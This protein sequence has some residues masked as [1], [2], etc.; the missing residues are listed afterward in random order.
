MKRKS[1]KFYP[2]KI[3]FNTVVTKLTDGIV[4]LNKKGIVQF[5]NPAAQ[6]L[7]GKTSKE[8]LD[9]PFPYKTQL[10]KISEFEIVHSRKKKLIEI[11]IKKMDFK[12]R[13]FLL[14]SLR[15]I[16]HRQYSQKLHTE[17]EERKK[18]EEALKESQALF[19]SFMNHS[20]TISAMKDEKGRYIYVNEPLE[21]LFQTTFSHLKGKTDFD[22]LSEPTAR[23]LW[24][25]DMRVLSSGKM[26][27]AIE[28]V[29]TPDGVP[30]YWLVLKFPFLH[31]T[32]KHFVGAVGI[33]ITEKKHAEEEIKILAKFPS[34][35]PYPIFRISKEGTILYANNSALPLLQSWKRKI[36]ENAPDHLRK[37]VA[38]TLETGLKKHVEVDHEHQIFSFVFA[39]IID[40]GYVNIYAQD[41]TERKRLEHLKEEFVSTVSHELRTP[42]AILK[43]G[44]SQVWEGLHGD[45]SQEQKKILAMALKGVDRLSNIINDLLDISKIEA[46]RV[47]LKKRLIDLTD[48]VRE[49]ISIFQVEI[50]NRKLALKSQFPEKPVYVYADRGKIFQVLTNL[51]GNA[52]KFTEKGFIEICVEN[53]QEAVICSVSD[54]GRSISPKDLSKVFEKFQQFSRT[55]GPGERGTGLG[56]SICKGLVESHGGK[57]WVE[58]KLGRG[59]RF[60]FTLPHHTSK[61]IFRE[62]ISNGIKEALREKSFVSIIIFEIKNFDDLK[63]KLGIDKVS[64]LSQ[65]L[66]DLIEQSFW[67]R[68]DI[69][70]RQTRT[71][72]I[73]LPA[74]G[75]QDSFL[76]AARIQR[77]ITDSL[78][79]QG[80]Q[81]IVEIAGSVASFPEDGETAEALIEFAEKRLQRV[82][83]VLIID[84]D[85]Q[86][87]T[88]LTQRLSAQ[89]Q[90]ECLIARDGMEALKKATE[91]FPD[92]IICDV[93][94]P[95]MNG[96]EVIGRLKED[97]KTRDIPIIILTAYQSEMNKIDAVLPGSI[98]ILSKTEGFDK[99]MQILRKMI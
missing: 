61:A 42:L 86:I 28:M 83:K 81:D 5:V 2:L 54:T 98:P 88:L 24:E 3:D 66:G 80:L 75:K 30:H 32:G 1:T 78:N 85:D 23:R 46:G 44:I 55:A 53:S 74:T 40:A 25:N 45:L 51:V 59:S 18:T 31:P 89:N 21:K 9:K 49:I 20:P 82:K 38:E 72:L 62:Y 58:S 14:A 57:I 96:Y 36:G 15:D 39:P 70:I 56:L 64:S 99:L 67:R 7:L 11:N 34:E 8:L 43:E 87:V 63:E 4:I 97:V 73:V 27:E 22:W 84:D 60:T 68:A 76:T 95:K 6:S 12:G 16:S 69:A 10:G 19:Q 37:W 65:E 90:F 17:I 13:S 91:S 41:I 26:L 50:K 52:L 94:L 48:L 92:L 35:D 29:P 71:I 47:I 77:L 93:K 79:Q 33:D